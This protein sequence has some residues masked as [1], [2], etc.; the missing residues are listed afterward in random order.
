MRVPDGVGIFTTRIFP[1]VW[2]SI[3]TILANGQRLGGTFSEV[4]T[5]TS[6]IFTAS[7][8]S[9]HLWRWIKEWIYSCLQRF[10]KCWQTWDK[11]DQR[12]IRFEGVSVRSTSGRANRGAP[13]R[14]WPGVRQSGVSSGDRELGTWWTSRQL[15]II[16]RLMDW[17][18]RWKTTGYAASTNDPIWQRHW[19]LEIDE[20][21][22]KYAQLL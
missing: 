6:P 11:R 17:Q 15:P 14:K 10:Q 4:K 5:T 18:G 22:L 12:E 8:W 21:L 7:V 13:I 3:S 20:F 19:Y 16:H 9:S 1:S 2:G